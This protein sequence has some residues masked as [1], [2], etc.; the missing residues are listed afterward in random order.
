MMLRH[1]YNV[2]LSQL[3]TFN[4]LQNPFV[5]GFPTKHHQQAEVQRKTWDVHFSFARTFG[6]HLSEAVEKAGALGVDLLF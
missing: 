6:K 4:I 5:T 2:L 3:C 1:R